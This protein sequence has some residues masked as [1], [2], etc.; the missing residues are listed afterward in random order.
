MQKSLRDTYVF[1]ALKLSNTMEACANINAH[2]PEHAI[3]SESLENV[4]NEIKYKIQFPYKL[5]IMDDLKSGAITLINS[6][7]VRLVPTWMI[8][9]S[10]GSVKT[11]VVN[12]FGKVKMKD[13]QIQFSVRDVYAMA[14]VGIVIKDF[15]QKEPRII[16]NLHLSKLAITIYE[17]MFYRVLDVLYSLDVGPV[18]LRAKVKYEISVFCAKY[19]LEKADNDATISFIDQSLIKGFNV[20]VNS[21]QSKLTATDDPTRF[22]SLPAFI[23]SLSQSNPILKDLDLTA[24]LRK[25]VMMYGERALLMIESYQYFLALV[26]SVT[27]SGNVVKDFGMESPVGKEGILL[28]NLYAEL[29][30]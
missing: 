27:V 13:K 9:A 19:M 30:R 29:T 24:F 4:I 17:R 3:D 16:H 5:R 7:E 1:N 15:Y 2:L 25:F 14:Q 10:D 18:W 20:T 12:L 11:A 6:P 8:G 22:D 21:L 23:Q 26:M 28:Y